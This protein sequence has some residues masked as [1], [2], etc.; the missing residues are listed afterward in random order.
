MIVSVAGWKEYFSFAST[1]FTVTTVGVGVG[2]G[3]GGD[4]GVGV[5]AEVVAVPPPHAAKSRAAAIASERKTQDNFTR[6]VKE[7]RFLFMT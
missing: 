6:W 7:D 5:G 4:V 3:L 1:I 2:V